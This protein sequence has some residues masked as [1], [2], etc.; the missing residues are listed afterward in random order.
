MPS[1]LRNPYSNTAGN[2][3]S[4]LSNG[5]IGVNQAD[6]KLFYRASNGTVTQLA[7]G[8]SSVAVY[9]SASLFPATGSASVIYLDSTRARLYRWVAADAVYAEIGTV[10]GIADSMDGGVYG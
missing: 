3:P 2:V 6:G 9:S 8:S 5:Q 1:V 7:S 4:S 10:G